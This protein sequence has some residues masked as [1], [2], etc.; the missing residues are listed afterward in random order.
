MQS[1]A[2]LAECKTEPSSLVLTHNQ[3]KILGKMKTSVEGHKSHPPSF[4][5]L[6]ASVN[7]LRNEIYAVQEAF[8]NRKVKKPGVEVRVS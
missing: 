1:S 7:E 6:K 8:L 3:N 4:D 5:E 2:S